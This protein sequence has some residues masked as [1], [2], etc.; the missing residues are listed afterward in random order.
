[1]FLVDGDSMEPTLMDEE[2]IIVDRSRKGLRE[3]Q[4]FV[5]NYMGTL[6]VKKIR[7]GL[8]GIDLNSDNPSYPPVPLNREE[9]NR[10]QVIG[11]A[12][13]SHRNF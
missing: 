1:M 8:N 6:W 12:V 7:M 5:L 2:E 4:I 11:Q 10:L 13:R 9:A 3:G